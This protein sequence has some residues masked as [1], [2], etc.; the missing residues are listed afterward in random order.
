MFRLNPAAEVTHQW[1][2]QTADKPLKQCSDRGEM[3]VFA[4]TTRDSCSA[5]G[6]KKCS[7]VHETGTL[8]HLKSSGRL[9]HRAM[10]TLALP[11]LFLHTAVQLARRGFYSFP[12][13]TR[14]TY[15]V[16]KYFWS[17][18]NG[19]VWCES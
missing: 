17:P 4:M 6:T 2:R 16:R 19:L 13:L 1:L 15:F 3:L 10:M 12:W 11:Y 5:F 14:Q 9:K 18:Q 7:T 8:K